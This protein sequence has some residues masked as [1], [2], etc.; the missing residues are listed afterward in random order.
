[1]ILE[2][3][4]I[5]EESLGLYLYYFILGVDY[6]GYGV[7]LGFN[8]GLSLPLRL[9]AIK[10]LDKEVEDSRVESLVLLRKLFTKLF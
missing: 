1:M 10:S 6:E 4:F 5:L 3:L 8:L 9:D 2:L 7:D